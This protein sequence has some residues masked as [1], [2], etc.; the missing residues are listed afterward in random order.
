MS[1][2]LVATRAL[3]QI[4]K[5]GPKLPQLIIAALLVGL[6]WGCY[7]WGV[8]HGH[9]V[10]TALGYFINPLV[11]VLLGV[12]VLG[13]KLR[14]AQWIALGLVGIAVTVLTL[15]YGRPPWISLVLAITFAFY[16]L[17]KKRAGAPAMVGLWVETLILGG[18]SLAYLLWL[19]GQ[20]TA[21]F[22]HAG[23]MKSGIFMLSGI[24][25]TVPLLCFA[26]A[27]NRVPLSTL[28]VIQ[29][30]SPTIQFVFGIFVFHEPMPASRWAGF[31][32]VWVAIILF[33]TK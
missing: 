16:G 11:S 24:V 10:E 19:E 27:A 13:E 18:P 23:M 30:I 32:L 25:T 21:V 2:L 1:L 5:L 29:Y 17:V 7:I 14:R 3:G 4:R 12:V 8:T 26:A 22:A 33:A 9:V 31:A 28:G 6:N 20:G 15:D